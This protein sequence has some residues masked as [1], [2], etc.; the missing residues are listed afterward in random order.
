MSEKQDRILIAD[1]DPGVLA[2][3]AWVLRLACPTCKV[4]KTTTGQA[5]LD[6]ITLEPPDI[7]ILDVHLPDIN[8]NEICQRLKADEATRHIPILMVT[9]GNFKPGGKAAALESGADAYLYKPFENAELAAQ[10]KVMLR[11]K[12]TEDSL[13]GQKFVLEAA[14]REQTE[15][16][17]HHRRALQDK[18]CILEDLLEAKTKALIEKDHAASDRLLTMGIAHEINNPSTFIASNL[19]TFEHFWVQINKALDPEAAPGSIDRRQI[20]FIRAEMPPLVEGMKKGVERI[21]TIIWHMKHYASDIM[22]NARFLTIP[23]LVRSALEM[24]HGQLPP[25]VTV[26]TEIP[27]TIPQLYGSEQMLSQVLVNLIA[28]AAHAI[29]ESGNPGVIHV[30]AWIDADVW[31]V[32]E[33]SDNGPGMPAAALAKIFNPFF[34]TRRN[35]G[36]TGLGLFFSQGIVKGHRGSLSAASVQG[37]G[38]TFTIRL[39]VANAQSGAATPQEGRLP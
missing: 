24:T 9:G 22:I 18:V 10:V 5:C 39:P 38:S 3:I 31:I 34:T 11:I 26:T 8:G 12:R 28:N 23:A 25:H 35:K 32:L 20:D 7:L 36:G 4:L 27:Q 30:R 33:V 14:V 6:A 17:E 29:G 13:R 2:S 16:L 1:D 21:S 37:S 19:Q 15:E